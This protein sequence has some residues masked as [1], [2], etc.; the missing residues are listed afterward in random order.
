[1]KDLTHDLILT[2]SYDDPDPEGC[3]V[4]GMIPLL[5]ELDDD[6][7]DDSS[8]ADD[9]KEDKEEEPIV[10]ASSIEIEVPQG[11]KIPDDDDDAYYALTEPGATDMSPGEAQDLIEY[12]RP[13][14]EEE[15]AFEEDTPFMNDLRW[16]DDP[17][18]TADVLKTGK[19]GKGMTKLLRDTSY[20]ETMKTEEEFADKHDTDN[21]HGWVNDPRDPQNRR[22]HHRHHHH[23]HHRQNQQLGTLQP[24]QPG[25][26]APYG[27]QPGQPG[28]VAPYG[29]PY[30]VPAYGQVVDPNA[31][32]AQAAFNA[33]HG[34]TSPPVVTT[35]PYA[36]NP[37]T[38]SPY[39]ANPYTPPVV[40]TL[41]P[42]Y[43][44]GGVTD[45]NYIMGAAKKAVARGLG[46]KLVVEHANWL[47][48]SDKSAGIAVRPRSYY[49]NVAKLWAKD[50]LTR[51]VTTSGG[52][53]A[54]PGDFIVGAN[55]ILTETARERTRFSRALGV[56]TDMG[57]WN[58]FSAAKNA[59]KKI[60]K[61]T[62]KYSVKSVVDPLKY[63]YKYGIKAP[64]TYTYKGVKYV[65]KMAEKMA[66]APL[67]AII[68]RLTGTMIS[69]RANLLA[70]QRGL[71]APGSAEK[72][73]ASNWAKNYVRAKGGKFGNV[74][75]SLMLGDPEY[76]MRKVDIS[77]SG[78][79][80][81]LGTAGTAGLILLGPIGLIALLTGL[82]KTSSPHAPP[83]APGS[84]EAQAE[85]DAAAQGA[86]DGSEDAGTTDAPPGYGDDGAADAPADAPADASA[87]TSGLSLRRYATIS[88][89]QLNRMN[90]RN[91][92]IAQ[93]LIQTGRLRLS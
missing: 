28:Y 59:V 4:Y 26:V 21:S 33:A 50:K 10:E 79:E 66:L 89:E 43:I 85:A 19:S 70:K 69:R 16:V 15:L 40:P 58:P 84:P 9:D 32:A 31:A 62:Y 22:R 6:K 72:L 17:A 3:D 56:D 41:T 78:D 29:T 52:A 82:V 27:T 47:A 57:G 44:P 5:S 74:I 81:G 93:K 39:P 61:T 51:A 48:D 13:A 35:N 2:T 45:D 68:N 7:E 1:M 76:G 12:M 36:T 67:R 46:R 23:H 86:G 20:G 92:T 63:G 8:G 38:T 83:P 91:K 49:E 11:E 14:S 24:G 80:M 54:T 75:A 60:A 90:P 65:G 42:G 25:Y 73:L 53:T 87:D 55:K 37:Y 30:G 18:H 34:G 71:P 88:V 77:L 64:L